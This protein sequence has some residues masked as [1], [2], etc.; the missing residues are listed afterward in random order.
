MFQISPKGKYT[1]TN[2]KPIHILTYIMICL[3]IKDN[4]FI[5][6]YTSKAIERSGFYATGR[7]VLHSYY[8]IL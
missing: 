3:E 5:I 4:H 6:N 2:L 1:F 7:F 8:T